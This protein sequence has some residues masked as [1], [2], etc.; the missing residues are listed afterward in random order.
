M[1][2]RVQL[3]SNVITLR[4]DCRVQPLIPA[5][6]N[7][8]F[9]RRV[10]VGVV[11]NPCSE[12]NARSTTLMRQHWSPLLRVKYPRSTAL[13]KCQSACHRTAQR[14]PGLALQHFSRD[15]DSLPVGEEVERGP[16]HP[17]AGFAIHNY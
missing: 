10:L 9:D 12:D 16:P 1:N 3:V 4:P 11:R 2:S 8:R 14:T 17:P 15:R 7:L 13:S 5:A 6:Q